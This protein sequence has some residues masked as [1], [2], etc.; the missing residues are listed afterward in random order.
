MISIFWIIGVIFLYIKEYNFAS[1]VW[2]TILCILIF[3]FR[4]RDEFT[5]LYYK[6]REKEEKEN[7]NED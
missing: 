1:I 7:R 6:V 5:K 3:I 2:L 4:N